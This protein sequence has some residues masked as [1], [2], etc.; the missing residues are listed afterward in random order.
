VIASTHYHCCFPLLQVL[1]KS[2]YCGCDL[3]QDEQ[4]QFL[5]H[6]SSI[7]LRRVNSTRLLVLAKWIENGAANLAKKSY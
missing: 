5:D 3:S 6:F 7:V 4:Q 1:K 2:D